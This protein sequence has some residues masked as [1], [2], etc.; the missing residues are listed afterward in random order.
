MDPKNHRKNFKRRLKEDGSAPPAQGWESIIACDAAF[1]DCCSTAAGDVDRAELLRKSALGL[2]GED[3]GALATLARLFSGASVYAFCGIAALV[4]A[5][6]REPA[7][8][9]GASTFVQC[10]ASV[11]LDGATRL[12]AASTLRPGG[13]AFALFNGSHGYDDPDRPSDHSTCVWERSADVAVAE[14]ALA[15]ESNRDA[16]PW[17]RAVLVPRRRL[18]QGVVFDII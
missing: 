15:G 17:L 9:G 12:A 1:L 6:A 3:A 18:L 7:V 5:C 16:E 11:I 4:D 8:F 13:L 10:D 2:L 14:D